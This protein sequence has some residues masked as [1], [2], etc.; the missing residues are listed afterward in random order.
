MT[1]RISNAWSHESFTRAMG[2][3]SFS[4]LDRQ[5]GGTNLS[6]LEKFY[7]S[8]SVGERGGRVGILAG[9]TFLDHAPAIL[10]LEDQRR[11]TGT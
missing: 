9:T 11:P 8:D 2:S 4:C 5:L 1:M 10:V 7:M 6:K 3:V